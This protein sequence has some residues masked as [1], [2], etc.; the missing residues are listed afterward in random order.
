MTFD[1]LYHMYMSNHKYSFVEPLYNENNELVKL[2]FAT[3]AC[4]NCEIIGVNTKP[5]FWTESK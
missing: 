2:V 1:E 5:D 4:S 3:V